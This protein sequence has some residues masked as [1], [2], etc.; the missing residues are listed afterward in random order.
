LSTTVAER[1][2]D[3]HI[4]ELPRKLQP[5][6]WRVQSVPGLGYRFLDEPAG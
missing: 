2:V 3:V 4:K 1:M 5:H 6:H